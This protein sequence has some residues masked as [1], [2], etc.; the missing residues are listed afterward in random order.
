M[1]IVLFTDYG[2]NG[3]YVGLVQN[4]LHQ[5]AP[6]L[7]VISLFNDIPR[8]NAKAAAYLLAAC[9]EEFPAGTIFF[10]VVDPGVGSFVDDPVILKIDDHYFVGP[11]NGLFDMVMRRARQSSCHRI[12]WK[13]ERLSNTFHGRD[14]YAPVC[15]MLANGEQ[16]PGEKIHWE[17]RHNW[18]DDLPEVIYIDGFGNCMTGMRKSFL[19]KHAVIHINQQEIKYAE[20]FSGVSAGEIFWYFNSLGLVELAVNKG[21]AA[22]YLQIKTGQTLKIF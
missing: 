21:S 19:K 2:N 14:L 11:D 18:P 17:D 3:P 7:T 5:Q 22:D 8:Q 12:S 15:S 4:V 20:T 13:P 10:A 1:M 9:V 6:E 16:V